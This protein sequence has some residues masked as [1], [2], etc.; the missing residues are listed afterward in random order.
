MRGADGALLD[1]P[2]ED[3][4][5]AEPLAYLAGEWASEAQKRA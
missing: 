1:D 2:D 4:A 5:N 3:E